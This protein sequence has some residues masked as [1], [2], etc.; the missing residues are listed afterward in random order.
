MKWFPKISAPAEFMPQLTNELYR[1]NGIALGF[2]A[3]IALAVFMELLMEHGWHWEYE[4][5]FAGQMIVAGGRIGLAKMY[6][7]AATKALA[8]RFWLRWYAFG[9]IL[10]VVLWDILILFFSVSWHPAF[11]VFVILVLAGV[12]AGGSISNTSHLPSAMGFVSLLMLPLA[13]RLF[14]TGID[15]YIILGGLVLWY[16]LGLILLANLGQR[17]LLHGLRQSQQLEGA[18]RQL[19]EERTHLLNLATTDFLTDLPNRRALDDALEAGIA[20]ARRNERVLAVGIIDLDDFKPVNDRY[21]HEAGDELLKVLARRM[22]EALRRHDFL[23]RLG[24]DEFVILMETDR[25]RIEG[26]ELALNRLHEAIT[27]PIDLNE[28]RQAQIDASLGLALFPLSSAQTQGELLHLADQAL[29]T[30]KKDKL[31]RNHWWALAETEQP[32]FP[33]P[34]D[35]DAETPLSGIIYG[36]AAARRLQPLYACI[37]VKKSLLEAELYRAIEEDSWIGSALIPGLTATDRVVLRKK[38][39]DH[40]LTLLKPE[41]KQAEHRQMALAHGRILAVTGVE[42]DVL[43]RLYEV[44]MEAI[45]RLDERESLHSHLALPVLGERWMQ[46]ARWQVEAAESIEVERDT[47]LQTLEDLAWRAFGYTELIE[48]AVESL[49]QIDGLDAATLARPDETGALQYESMAG[50]AFLRYLEEVKAKRTPMISVNSASLYGQGPTSRAWRTA[51]IQTGSNYLA[52]PTLAPWRDITQHLGVRSMAAVPLLVSGRVRNILSLYLRYPGGLASPGQLRF[53]GHIQRLLSLG[54]ARFSEGGEPPLKALAERRHF[55]HLLRNG[56]LCMVYQPIIHLDTG[57]L[58]KIEA[59]ARLRTDRVWVTPAQFLPVFD[60]NDLY[61]LY[62]R[63]LHQALATLTGL[64]AQS[65]DSGLSFNLPAPG[66]ADSRY[67][68]ATRQA[69]AEFPLG[70]QRLSLEVLETEVLELAPQSLAGLFKP[71]RELGVQFAE[72]DLGSGNSSLTRLRHIPFD[73]VKIDQGL[74]RDAARD[75]VRVLGFVRELTRL[76]HELGHQVVVEGLENDGLIEAAAV[77]GADFGQ[78]YGIARPM[79][80]EAL[81]KWIQTHLP[82]I[83]PTREIH[84]PLGALAAFR[85]WETRWSG[86]EEYLDII[87]EQL[88]APVYLQGFARARANNLPDLGSLLAQL[89]QTLHECKDFRHP[90][91]RRI[92]GEFIA[93]LSAE[94]KTGVVENNE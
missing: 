33:Y 80:A 87:D 29:Y 76:A 63:G 41:L 15:T 32:V 89:R 85:R 88:L 94:I 91:Y 66:L 60:A 65:V 7:S 26:L 50:E 74:V 12:A 79:P 18:I 11:Q 62:A 72:D 22:R 81:P 48:T 70:T 25:N 20:R 83:M 42:Q 45:R 92:R 24:G 6:A 52:D 93:L 67:L 69:L 86:L 61:D 1:R 35:S 10:S 56:G 19:Q 77:L 84:T 5:W 34:A 55:R 59:L 46:E 39:G 3:G 2:G 16:G 71:W 44:F 14:Y 49:C 4:L 17:A 64:S 57:K 40:A 82:I 31:R 38:L 13:A 58:A 90:D 8:W 27:Q 73:V 28:G 9:L 47:V 43:M 30:A 23:A 54:I 53:L 68:E 37:E 78:G 51:Q 36:E 21:G 75:P